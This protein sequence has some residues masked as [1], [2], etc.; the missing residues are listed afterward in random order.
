MKRWILIGGGVLV[1]AAIVVANIARSGAPTLEARFSPVERRDVTATIS[2]P[3]RVRAVSSVDLSAEVPGRVVELKVEEGD[4]VQAGDLLLR[5]DD[6]QY[7]SRVEQADAALR[8]ARA[9]LALSEARLEKTKSDLDRL[10]AMS[11]KDL[12]SAQAVEQA[13]TD[14]RVQFAEVE[15]RRQEVAR[16]EAA[17]SDARDN[18]EKTVYRAPVSGVISRLNVDQGEIVITGTMNNPGTVILTIADLSRMEVEAEVDETDVVY[19]RSGQRSTITVDAIPDTT[20]G[21]TVSSVGN[22]GRVR[23][24]GGTDEIINFEVIVGFDR[25]DPR[26]KPGMTADI[27]VQTRTH[28][29]V[30]AVPIQALVARSRGRIDD[31]RKAA[32]RREKGKSKSKEAVADTAAVSRPDSLDQEDRDKWRKEV[33]E[34]VYKVQDGKTVF[35]EVEAGIADETHIEITGDLQEGDEVV[36]G[37]YK[38]LRE[39]KEGT[40]VKQSDKKEA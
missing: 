17:L 8:S 10:Q 9:N 31:D 30:L 39:L 11:E 18:L 15:S 40:R 16:Q 7:K 13:V 24:G 5:L 23:G 32:L 6:N 33:V 37:P 1:L 26:L 36:S 38:V 34:G 27:E 35:V 12:A 14:H 19:V 20:F 22:S 28:A 29:G 3:G 25:S 21:G 4:S 2:A